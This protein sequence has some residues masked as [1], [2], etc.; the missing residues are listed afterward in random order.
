MSIL[1][2]LEVVGADNISYQYLNNCFVKAKANKKHNDT[3]VTFC[4]N[5][6]VLNDSGKVGLIIWVD[7]DKLQS[8]V[9][10]VLN[11]TNY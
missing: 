5:V 1:K 3:E 6:D 10:E 7:A 8:A 4:T 2:A 9:D 11:D